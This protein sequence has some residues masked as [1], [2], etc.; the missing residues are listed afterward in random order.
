VVLSTLILLIFVQK[1][2]KNMATRKIFLKEDRT[3]LNPDNYIVDEELQIVAG[4]Y[5]SV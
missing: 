2:L 4:K 1:E 3:A 5:I